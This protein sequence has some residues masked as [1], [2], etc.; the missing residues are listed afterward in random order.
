M[1][2]P[3]LKAHIE[4]AVSIAELDLGIDIVPKQITEKAPFDR[5]EYRSFGYLTLKH[6][7]ISSI[8]KMTVAPSNNQDI[9][10]IP[11]D[12]I[13]T[14]YLHG[15]QLSLMPLT[16]VATTGT[17][18]SNVIGA[19][20]FTWFTATNW[21]PAFWQ[22]TYTAGFCDMKLPRTINQL[23]GIIA[24]QE[25][26]SI[27]ATTNAKNNSMSLS[28]DGMSQSVG[29][30]GPEIY[31]VRYKELQEKRDL[32]TKKLKRAANL[33]MFSDNW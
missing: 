11:L 26:L 24:S 22:C 7:P 6:R 23:I 25:I 20:I 4:E 29:N 1:T 17:I 5:D 28:L 8:E 10:T 19:A 21:V 12:W 13:E 27:L 2:D 3:V 31:G 30:A 15:G 32:L 33:G 14:S 9:W 18:P 16:V